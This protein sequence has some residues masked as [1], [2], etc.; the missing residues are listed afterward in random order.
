MQ[1]LAFYVMESAEDLYIYRSG[2]QLVGKSGDDDASV[3]PEWK[4]EDIGESKVRCNQ[5]R[6]GFL[7]PRE[8]SLVRV[9]AQAHVADIVCR[10]SCLAQRLSRRARHVLVDKKRPHSGRRPHCF[11]VH[12]SGRIGKGGA[13]VFEVEIVFGRDFV[14]R[15]ATA[16]FRD[17]EAHR[18]P[19]SLDNWLAEA[20]IRVRHNSRCELRS[21]LAL[22]HGH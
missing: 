2:W 10:V 5:H 17:N 22:R 14:H 19:C 18:N 20:N 3:S 15:H 9:P 7:R 21:H 11:G 4:R 8:D 6:L 13:N 16:E 1:A 12:H